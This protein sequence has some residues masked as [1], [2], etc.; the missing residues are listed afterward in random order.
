MKQFEYKLLTINAA[1]LSKTNFQAEINAK[2]RH[3]GNEGWELD[4]MEPILTGSVFTMGS[5]TSEFLLVLKRE[6]I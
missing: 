3:W 6:K 2:F 4:K 5:R 1:H